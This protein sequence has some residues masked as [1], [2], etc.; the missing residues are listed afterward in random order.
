MERIFARG[1]VRADDRAIG[2]YL[3]D[4]LTAERA[5]VN[6]GGADPDG[7]VG[8]ADGEVSAGGRGHAVV[9]ETV[10]DRDDPVGGVHHF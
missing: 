9:V 5:L 4:I 2:L 1:L 7:A 8:I 3:H 6:A 10:H